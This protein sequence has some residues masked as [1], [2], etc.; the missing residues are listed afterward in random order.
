MPTLWTERWWAHLLDIAIVAFV[1]Y[2][3]LVAFQGTLAVQ[4]LGGLALLM[5]AR[6]AARQAELSTVGFILENFWALWVLALIVLFQPELRRLLAQLGR[7]RVLERVLAGTA[8]ERRH[9]ITEVARAA[10]ALAAKRVG[11][12]VAIERSTGLRAYAEL[13][14]PVDAALTAELLGTLF[15]PGSPL[16]DGAVIVQGDRLTAAGVFLPLSRNLGLARTLG[17]RHRAAVGLSEETDAV[18]VVVSEETGL[19]SLAVEGRLETGLDGDRL[20]R[21]LE[22]LLAPVAPEAA[23]SRW[24]PAVRRLGARDKA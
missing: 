17:T 24:W 3:L 22:E 10:D 1:I 7:S 18:V 4:M 11:A 15:L 19:V 21:R 20:T 8:V 2:R 13:G 14:V 9:V 12:L 5:L 23:G 6:F 16:H